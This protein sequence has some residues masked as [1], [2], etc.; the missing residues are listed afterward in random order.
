MGTAHGFNFQTRQIGL[1]A[2]SQ[3]PS[4]FSSPTRNFRALSF[5][6][7]HSYKGTTFLK[8]GI[9]NPPDSRVPDQVPYSEPSLFRYFPSNLPCFQSASRVN[10]SMMYST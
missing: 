2:R 4:N 1:S 5:S 3:P 10:L 7:R 8:A 6:R 9:A